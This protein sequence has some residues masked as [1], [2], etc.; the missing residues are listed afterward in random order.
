MP[1]NHVFYDFW[2]QNRKFIK[3]LGKCNL[4]NTELDIAKMGISVIVSHMNGTRKNCSL[5]ILGTIVVEQ[6]HEN[7]RDETKC[8]YLCCFGIAPYFQ[9]LLMA[10]LS[11]QD[12]CVLLFEESINRKLQ[13]K[14]MDYHV[15]YWEGDTVKYPYIHSYFLGHSTSQD[16]FISYEKMSSKISLPN[17]SLL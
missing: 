14:Q 17:R 2:L 16:M 11:K 3:L 8:V 12:T 4:C 6:S 5:G 15:C 9:S 1:G 10:T 13:E 7:V